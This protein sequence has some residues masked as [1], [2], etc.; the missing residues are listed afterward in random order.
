ME[1]KS[2]P[3]ARVFKLYNRIALTGAP[4]CGKTTLAKTIKD[5]PVFYSD[6]FKHLDWSDASAEIARV[7]NAHEGPCLVEGVAVARALRKGMKVDAVIYLTQPKI[8]Q[9]PGQVVMGRG[10]RTVLDEWRAKNPKIPVYWEEAGAY[11]PFNE[12]EEQEP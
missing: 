4:S 1:T 7:V 2:K 9:K 12:T 11:S 10:I 6:D 5:R 8:E 3:F